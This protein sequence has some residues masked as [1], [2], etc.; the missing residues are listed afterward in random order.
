MATIGAR[1]PV[2]QIRALH[3]QVSGP[4]LAWLCVH[5]FF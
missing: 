2:A 5:I 1:T 4:G 3:R